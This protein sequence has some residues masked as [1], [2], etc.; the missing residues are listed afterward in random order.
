VRVEGSWYPSV[1][2]FSNSSH[3]S[4]FSHFSHTCLS[5]LSLLSHFRHTCLSLLA[6]LSHSERSARHIQ[7]RECLTSLTKVTQVRVSHFSHLSTVSPTRNFSPTVSDSDRWIPDLSQQFEVPLSER[8]S[9]LDALSH[10]HAPPT[11]WAT[12]ILGYLTSLDRS[13]CL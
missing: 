3:F 10:L 1:S 6:H 12:L 13:R 4:H 2:H 9:H 11:R 8:L 5:L 7:L